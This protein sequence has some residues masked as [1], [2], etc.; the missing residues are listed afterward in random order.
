[1]FILLPSKHSSKSYSCCRLYLH[2]HV[3][4][5]C[6]L[7][8]RAAGA[9]SFVVQN[10]RTGLFRNEDWTAQA[11]YSMSKNMDYIIYV[12][13]NVH[14]LMISEQRCIIKGQLPDGAGGADGG[15]ACPV[16]VMV[17]TDHDPSLDLGLIL[18]RIFMFTSEGGRLKDKNHQISKQKTIKSLFLMT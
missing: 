12:L 2:L 6:F 15:A 9:Q 3:F 18:Y 10:P 16:R 7:S 1:M 4:L 13:I 5:R 14:V 11:K 17:N 8:A